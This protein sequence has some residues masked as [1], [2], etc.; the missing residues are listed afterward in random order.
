MG[1]NG[2]RKVEREYDWD[3]KAEQILAQY[4]LVR[5]GAS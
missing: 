1:A 2:R 4:R 5:A 3:V